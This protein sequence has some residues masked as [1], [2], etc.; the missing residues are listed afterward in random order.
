MKAWFLF[1]SLTCANLFFAQD[2]PNVADA[3]ASTRSA[4]VHIVSDSFYM[5]QLQRYRRVLIYLPPDYGKTRKKY[6]VLYMHDGQNLFDDAT[7]FV[8][9]W[10]VDENLNEL[11]KNGGP[12]LIVV[13]ID[14]GEKKRQDELSPW[15]NEKYG[16]GEGGAYTEFIVETL[17]PFIDKNYRTKANDT[18]IGGSSM[19]GLISLYAAAKYPTVFSKVLVFSP[20]FWFALPQVKQQLTGA[21]FRGTKIYMIAGEKESAEMVDDA[22]QIADVLR[23]HKVGLLFKTDADGTHSEK[24]W[25]REFP[26]AIRY[27]YGK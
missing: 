24:Y 10:Q 2:T 22:K 1:L 27:L 14:H 11:A 16:G 9:E 12:Q 8:G 25:N 13:G 3:K 18:G 17:K 4:N 5:P 23:N 19:G 7:S 21:H 15:K 6:P 26:A 20:A